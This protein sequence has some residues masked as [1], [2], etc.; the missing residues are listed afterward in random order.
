MKNVVADTLSQLPI[1]NVGDLQAISRFCSVDDVKA[2]F[3]SAV[4]QAENGEAWLPDIN[5]I[6]TDLETELLYLGGGSRKSFQTYFSKF[7]NENDAIFRLI[8]LCQQAKYNVRI[9]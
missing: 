2:I 1:N 6:N 3:D 8:E 7:Q 4:N 9:S 5:I